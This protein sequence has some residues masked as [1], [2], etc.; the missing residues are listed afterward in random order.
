M[1]KIA[2]I[3][4]DASC[5]EKGRIGGNIPVCLLKDI[6]SFKHYKFFLMVQNPSASNEY[7]SIFVPE[8]Y[9]IMVDNNIYPNCSLKVFV[10][11]FSEESDNNDYTLEG[12]RKCSLTEFE[13][14]QDDEYGF[15]TSGK[16]PQLIQDEDYYFEKLKEDGFDFFLQIDEDYYPDGVISGD[17]ILGYGAMYLYKHRKTNEIIVGFWQYS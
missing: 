2:N 15:I 10:H 11:S 13:E 3:S 17:Y 8:S 7:L 5:N 14:V 1:N 6:D 16:R 12:V 9:D 4:S